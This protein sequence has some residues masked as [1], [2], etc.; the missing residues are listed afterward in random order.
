MFRIF[1]VEPHHMRLR[2]ISIALG[3]WKLIYRPPLQCIVG[4][5]FTYMYIASLFRG[6]FFGGRSKLFTGMS[7]SDMV[8]WLVN[9]LRASIIRSPWKTWAGD[10]ITN[11]WSDHPLKPG[12]SFSHAGHV[13]W[14]TRAPVPRLE[15][16]SWVYPRPN[17]TSLELESLISANSR[18]TG[19]F[20]VG[21]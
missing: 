11:R 15:M 5:R 20:F 3:S 4:L 9:G 12:V 2:S 13:I 1:F 14:E 16:P 17:M 21:P 18:R 7:K 6:P 19:K 8:N 10:I